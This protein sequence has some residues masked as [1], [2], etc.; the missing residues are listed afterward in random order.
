M[1]YAKKIFGIYAWGKEYT[2]GE[3]FTGQFDCAKFNCNGC[4]EE[5]V[6]GEAPKRK[7]DSNHK[8]LKFK[9]Q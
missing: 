2:L 3:K 9:F 6:D 1:C 4:N 7:K 5:F 8:I